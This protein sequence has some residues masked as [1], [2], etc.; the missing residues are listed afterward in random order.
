[1]LLKRSRLNRIIKKSVAE[2]IEVFENR[3]PVIV[4]HFYYGAF[5]IAP[6]HLVIW[7]LY[8]TNDELDV[9]KKS[10]LCDEIVSK[11]KELL[12]KHKYPIDALADTSFPIVKV[13]FANGTA[14]EQAEIL[15][16]LSHGKVSVSFTTQQD[17]KEKTN[18][19]YH[20]YF[21]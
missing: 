6:Q 8:R 16:M 18:G 20:L 13:K 1:M 19:D 17:I 9:A 7:Y 12:K 2:T 5:D 3:R 15:H 11:T 10:G 14:E 21:Q 4:E